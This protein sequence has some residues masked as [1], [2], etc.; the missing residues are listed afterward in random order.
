MRRV[1]SQIGDPFCLSIGSLVLNFSEKFTLNF[2][3]P[4]STPLQIYTQNTFVRLRHGQ[5][6]EKFCQAKQVDSWAKIPQLRSQI[7]LEKY[8]LLL[9]EN[10]T[11]TLH[12]VPVP[13][14]HIVPSACT[15][16]YTCKH[17]RS[18]VHK[19][20]V[21]SRCLC[22]LTANGFLHIF[23]AN[24]SLST[25]VLQPT[26][27]NKF[28]VVGHLDFELYNTRRLSLAKGSSLFC[29]QPFMLAC[30]LRRAS[31]LG[32]EWL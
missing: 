12:R 18:V 27:F 2:H 14:V 6:T 21:A 24:T 30:L 17:T 19:W 7:K 23:C 4:P 15:I 8:Q 5:S 13:S 31:M 3:D 20:R 32:K 29:W 16:V 26:K 1:E 28:R 11:E 22:H 9:V 10:S 25:N